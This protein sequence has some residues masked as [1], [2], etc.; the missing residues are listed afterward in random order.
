[1]VLAD[2][3]AEVIRVDRAGK[4]SGGDPDD[5]P[6]DLLNR[7]RRSVASRPQAPRRRRGRARPGGVGRRAHRGLPARRHGAPRPRSRRVPGPQP[8]AGVRPHDRLGPGRALRPDRRP[9][10]QLHRPRRRAGPIGRAG[11][12]PD[13]ADQPGRRLRR[14]RHA[15][16]PRHLRRAARGRPLRSGPGGRRGHGRRRR[17]A[18]DDD[19]LVPGHGHLGATT[20][21][22]T[23]STPAPTSTTPT[24][25]ADGRYVSIGSIEPQFYAELLRLTGL[26]GE[27]LP[28]QQDRTAVAGLKERLAGDLQGED[29]RR[30]V[31]DHGGHRRLLRPGAVAGR[32]A[33]APAQRARGTFVEVAGIVQP[34]PAPRFSRT[35]GAIRRPPPHAGQHTDEVL[36]ELGL[37]R[38]ADRRAAASRRHRVGRVGTSPPAVH[39]HL[40]AFSTTSR[41]ASVTR[42]GPPP[43]PRA[44]SSRQPAGRGA[45]HEPALLV[46]HV[47]PFARF[48]I[49]S[50]V[51][52]DD[53]D[54]DVADLLALCPGVLLDLQ[55][56]ALLDIG[57]V[58]PPRGW[59][60]PAGR[61]RGRRRAT[62]SRR[63]RARR[64]GRGERRRSLR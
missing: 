38:R 51:V 21:A 64:S 44:P 31:R 36:A 42:S 24:R 27:E 32:G 57:R 6:A 15:A 55:V 53:R 60:P 28:W 43:R 25:C 62:G 47:C 20:A 40:A 9:R 45:E 37:R 11:E 5:P 26:E 7:G 48:G 52:G 1:M 34:A 3:G 61:A 13:A 14:R 18:H 29:P 33:R 46:L 59:G 12:A 10:H 16:R 39:R 50:V 30:V 2:L 19:P 4:A 49:R 54:R 22:R 17:P 8:E 63:R 56:V 35:P 41:I 23:C 58:V